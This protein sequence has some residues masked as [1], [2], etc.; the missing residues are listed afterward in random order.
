LLQLLTFDEVFPVAIEVAAG[1]MFLLPRPRLVTGVF[2]STLSV[3]TLV[4]DGV[5]IDKDA[6]F[7]RTDFCVRD[8]L[9]AVDMSLLVPGADGKSS[10]LSTLVSLTFP[11][12]SAAN[13]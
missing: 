11:Y 6:H 12:V 7:E 9:V 5:A 1:M 2:A 4:D 3:R 10:S 13:V 8:S